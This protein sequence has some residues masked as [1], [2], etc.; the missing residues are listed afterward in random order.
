MKA[1]RRG[2]AMLAALWLVVG[3]T[4]VALEFALSAKERRE[5]GIAAAERGRA[6][7]AALGAFAMTRAKLEYA[8]RAGPQGA[9]GSLGR[10]QSSDPWLGVDSI[11]SG[12]VAVDSLPVTVIAGDLGAKLNINALTEAELR[13]FFSYL[14]GDYVLS[15]Q[16]AQAI[17]DW[18]DV[19][20]IP[21]VRGGER[22]DYIKAGLLR[23]PAN[24]DF[25]DLEDLLD[26]KGM[27]PQ[28]YAVVS[29]Y[30]TTLGA[31]QVNLN[32]APVPVLR[33][34]PGMNDEII[35]RIL[36][37]R[38]NGS[39]I[40]SVAEVMPQQRGM[41][42]RAGAAMQAVAQNAQ[43]QISARAGVLTQQVELTILAQASSSARPVR[44]RVLLARENINGQSAAGV[45][46]EEWR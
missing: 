37:L 2:V 45:Q 23:L 30:L 16:L 18:R 31:A 9:T 3:I 17:S 22:D 15:D 5:L 46:N 42:G 35:S 38:S 14:L 7:G 19:D 36:Q 25:R 4:V 24:Q 11:Y 43:A 6:S 28:I 40:T 29:P 21:R 32:S 44:L 10:L 20:D 26:V 41:G 13:T 1:N 39:R 34:L 27:T 8:L 12:T 33:V